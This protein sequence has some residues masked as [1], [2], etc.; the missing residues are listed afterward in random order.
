MAGGARVHLP[1]LS[2]SLL[3][4]LGL[5]L[6]LTLFARSPFSSSSST[7]QGDRIRRRLLALG[8]GEPLPCHSTFSSLPFLS[9]LLP[10]TATAS[11]RRHWRLAPSP[12]SGP[13]RIWG[14]GISP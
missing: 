2:L 7:A 13:C 5:S 1:A 9:W 6:F 8:L 4:S 12:F 3:L 10:Q 11:G 14:W